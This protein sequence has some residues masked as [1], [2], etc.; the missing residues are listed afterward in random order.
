MQLFL[1]VARHEHI[2]NAAKE[3]GLSQPYL[4]NTISN[5]ES[6]LG[7]KLFYREGRNIRLTEAGRIVMRHTRSIC[8]EI[9]SMRREVGHLREQEQ[10]ILEIASTSARFFSSVIKEFMPHNE[11]G[12]R[13]RQSVCH[14]QELKEMIEEGKL[15]FCISAPPV[16]GTN[17][18]TRFLCKD[19]IFLVVPNNHWLADR[20][21]VRLSEARNEKFLKP[22]ISLTFYNMLEGFCKQA[23]FVPSPI[24]EGD[25]SILKEMLHSGIGVSLLPRSFISLSAKNYQVL[26]VIEPECTRTLALSWSKGRVLSPAELDFKRAIMDYYDNKFLVSNEKEIIS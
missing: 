14:P 1:C 19:E 22:N 21:I 17:I 8:N 9:E 15:D 7:T 11:Y 23:G 10:Q 12:L 25:L 4:S 20:E 16:E 24:W 6:E 26:K 3:L 5:L 18:E 2:T 13:F